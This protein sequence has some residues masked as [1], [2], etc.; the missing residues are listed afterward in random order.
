MSADCR[1]SLS[2]ATQLHA[3][4]GLVGRDWRLVKFCNGEVMGKKLKL[5]GNNLSYNMTKKNKHA[6]QRVLSMS[7]TAD[8]ASEAKVSSLPLFYAHLYNTLHMFIYIRTHIKQYPNDPLTAA[9]LV[10]FNLGYS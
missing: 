7:L 9:I 2:A 3:A 4:A 5:Q 1:F 10:Y 6:R 8:I